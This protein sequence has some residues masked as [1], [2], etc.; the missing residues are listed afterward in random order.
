MTEIVIQAMCHQFMPFVFARLHHVIKVGASLNHR[1]AAN[2]LP[3]HD[4]YKSNCDEPWRVDIGLVTRK[5]VGRNDCLD[6]GHGVSYAV[7]VSIAQEERSDF[8]DWGVVCS[9]RVEL[10]KV[11]ERERTEKHTRPPEMAAVVCEKRSTGK[12]K[13]MSAT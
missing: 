3:N 12:A 7:L 13:H 9:C 4:H 6:K 2:R 10:E 8:G 11:E 1:C 5:E